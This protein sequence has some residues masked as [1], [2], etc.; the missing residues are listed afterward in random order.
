[1]H[2]NCPY[3]T[4]LNAIFL[5][6]GGP[7]NLWEKWASSTGILAKLCISSPSE[8]SAQISHSLYHFLV[9]HCEHLTCE[10]FYKTTM[11]HSSVYCVALRSFSACVMIERSKVKGLLPWSCIVPST[12]LVSGRG[13]WELYWVRFVD[14][15]RSLFLIL[16]GP[17][18]QC[19]ALHIILRVLLS[20]KLCFSYF[21][22][23]LYI[24]FCE[25][26]NQMHARVILLIKIWSM[27]LH[28][29]VPISCI[30]I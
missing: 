18:R 23:N 11:T 3:L 4:P 7:W 9:L 21:E 30:S 6:L 16:K 12:A 20:L 15:V 19:M 26:G 2:R 8:T 13:W 22:Y 1:M 10:N 5:N 28:P 24:V 17:R 29:R 14:H 25:W 27:H